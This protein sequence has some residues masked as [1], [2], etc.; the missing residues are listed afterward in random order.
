MDTER[1]ISDLHEDLW[2]GVV[3]YNQLIG[4]WKSGDILWF[5]GTYSWN[6]CW[7]EVRNWAVK[8]NIEMINKVN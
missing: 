7:N 5:T 2:V 4:A 3:S 6:I 1:L 8:Y